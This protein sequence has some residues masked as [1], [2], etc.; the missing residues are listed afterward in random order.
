MHSSVRLHNQERVDEGVVKGR[1]GV[2]EGVEG[3]VTTKRSHINNA[4]GNN[5]YVSAK[6]TIEVVSDNP[7]RLSESE[8]DK[9]DEEH[10]LHV[11]INLAS[12]NKGFQDLEESVTKVN[13]E[14]L[15]T[16]KQLETNKT[17]MDSTGDV[18]LCSQEA[19]AQLEEDTQL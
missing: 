11:I 6:P 1:E 15:T 16:S 7:T 19:L 8:P 3:G 9:K 5:T 14:K 2:Y 10:H 4:Y 13:Q 17:T 18:V 12:I